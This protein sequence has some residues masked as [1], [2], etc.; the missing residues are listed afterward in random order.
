MFDTGAEGGRLIALALMEG[1]PVL[2]DL[3]SVLNGITTS[4][5]PFE[6][7]H[8]LTVA[9]LMVSS[10][11]QVQRDELAAPLKDPAVNSTWGTDTSRSSLAKTIVVRLEN[12]HTG[13]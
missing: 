7:F 12:L 6:Q 8:A 9:N 2:A 4:A 11:N 5:S 13:G 1:D 3:P 10:L